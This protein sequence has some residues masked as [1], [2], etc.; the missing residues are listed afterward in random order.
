[1]IHLA[2]AIASGRGRSFADPASIERLQLRRLRAL[3][4][5]AWRRVAIHRE[6]LDAAGVGPDGI[7]TLTDVRRIPIMAKAVLRETPVAALV[8]RGFDPARGDVVRT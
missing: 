7:R 4:R 1:M 8:V 3:V 2:Y 6:R 5:H